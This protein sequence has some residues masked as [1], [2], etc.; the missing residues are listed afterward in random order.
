MSNNEE[1]QLMKLTKCE[2]NKDNTSLYT[3]YINWLD[4]N[5]FHTAVQYS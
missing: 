2:Q 5:E 1:L 3:V 4:N